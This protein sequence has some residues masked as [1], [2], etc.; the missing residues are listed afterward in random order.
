MAWPPNAGESITLNSHGGHPEEVE[1][2]WVERQQPDGQ[3]LVR[4]RQI[5]HPNKVVMSHMMHSN[6]RTTRTNWHEE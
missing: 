3:C 1:V 5:H 2:I 6:G 4:V